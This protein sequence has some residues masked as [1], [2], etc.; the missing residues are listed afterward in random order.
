[1]FQSDKEFGIKTANANS[2]G[3]RIQSEMRD[4]TGKC[5][6]AA[7]KLGLIG[8]VRDKIVL[9]EKG[10]RFVPGFLAKSEGTSV[11]RTPVPTPQPTQNP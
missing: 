6:A 10:K 2:D 1:M 3:T 9:T 8:F 5:R 4:L 7:F 11:D